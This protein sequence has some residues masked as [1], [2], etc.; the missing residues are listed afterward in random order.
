MIKRFLF[1]TLSSFTGT[2]IAMVIVGIVTAA[3]IGVAVAGLSGK[4]ENKKTEVKKGCILTINL[5]GEIQ[6]CE[7]PFS[8][9]LYMLTSGKFEVPQ[10]LHDICTSLKEAAANK[11][12]AA[13]YLKCGD[14]SA[15]PATFDAI[16]NAILEFRET[17]NGEKKVYAYAEDFN[18]GCYYVATAADSIFMN[19]EGSFALKGLTMTNFYFKDLLDKAG[20]SMQIAKVG[21]YKSAVEPYTLTHMS[22]PA[23]AQLDTMLT[24]M[25]HHITKNISGSRSGIT[26]AILD[27]LI[28]RDNISF[29]PTELILNYKL[30]DGLLYDRQM[31]EKL[32][33]ASGGRTD[34]LNLVDTHVLLGKT[35]K[36]YKNYK[37]KKQIAVVYAV[38]DI[39]DGNDSQIDYNRFVPLI[40]ELADEEGVKA[41]VL[42]VNSPG[43]SV[44][45]SALIGEALDY[46]KSKGKP[47]IVSMGDYAA[48]GGYWI[49]AK[50]DRIFADPMTLTG[51]I[52]I[53]GMFPCV[54]GTAKMLGVNADMV[55]TN[56]TASFPNLFKHLSENQHDVLQKYV[57]R[58]YTK[59]I[60]CVA[61]GR[62]MAEERVR[63]I[64]EGR[65]WVGMRALQMG[66]V[67]ELG[68]LDEAIAYAA[69][70]AEMD[71]GY[72]LAAYPEYDPSFF[73][74]V[75]SGGVSAANLRTA[76]EK[77]D[78]SI[79]ETYLVKR[80]T[81]RHP[82]QARMGEFAITL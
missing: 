29:A 12:V 67:D 71:K 41:L 39:E 18:Q 31:K 50:A 75:M 51:S 36:A 37:S 58:G 53:F 44:Y 52:G 17:T 10:T 21:T 8:P 35:K 74:M 48:S 2:T 65:V 4:S 5:S 22:E 47:L 64:A 59:F 24:D 20:I 49:S 38:G 72:E 33:Y 28:D 7:K 68:G 73:D 61:E 54:E 46:F 15:A 79:I 60:D 76:I 1:H 13:V 16:R 26:P 34:K 57:E 23:R 69:K 11:D 78:L 80:L 66:L 14:L 43:G 40:N 3:I 19:P 63:Q 70:E 45:G 56:P 77:Q 27:S 62:H 9:S 55:S 6:E 32:A 81:T 30:V 25:W 42:R 82:F